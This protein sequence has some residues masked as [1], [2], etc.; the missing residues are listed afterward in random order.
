LLFLLKKPRLRYALLV[1]LV[2]GLKPLTASS[3][4]TAEFVWDGDLRARHGLGDVGKAVGS[5]PA[6]GFAVCG[7][8]ATLARYLEICKPHRLTMVDVGPTMSEFL[9]DI[10]N[11]EGSRA[12]L[13]SLFSFVRRASSEGNQY[14]ISKSKLSIS[15]IA[16]TPDTESTNASLASW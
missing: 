5:Q 4:T 6:D 15:M 9:H 10:P 3:K 7:F 1:G 8:T 16:V 2:A 14:M 13:A 11:F 12:P